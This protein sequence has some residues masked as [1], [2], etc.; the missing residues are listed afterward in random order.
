MK[1][2]LTA[3]LLLNLT[4][5]GF[6][7]NWPARVFAPYMYIGANDNFK[8]ARCADVCGQKFYTIAFII[9]NKCLSPAWYGRIPMDGN[10]YADQ[11]NTI[12]SRG[13]D[14][15]VSFGGADGTE[16]AIAE[17]N[18]ALLEAKYQ[19]VIDQY[20]FSWLDFD[21]EGDA[22]SNKGANE[23]RNLVLTRL[24]AK[25]PGLI[26]SFTLPVDPD[27][28][29]AESRGLLADAK[30]QGVKVHSANVMTM[31]FGAHFS[32]GRRMSDVSIV[33]TIK[34]HEQC[35]S[36]DSAI[37]IGVTPMIGQNDE[38]GEIFTQEDARALFKWAQAQPWVCSLSFWASNRDAGK[39]GKKGT[40]NHT[41]GIEQK[42]WEFTS[43]FE[44]FTTA[45]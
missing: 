45:N 29:S 23:R 16:L 37:Q 41:S 44:P 1:Y 19:S 34:A 33:S 13:G 22:L 39:S 17:T 40:D 24:Q 4:A 3:I 35:Q 14:V 12:R 27:G 5:T 10:L 32:K 18:A 38:P 36:I 6:S 7:A 15:I 43:I 8:I 31:D 21:I 11:I 2:L 26:I 28:I 25:N 20:K 9:A 30:A 42:P